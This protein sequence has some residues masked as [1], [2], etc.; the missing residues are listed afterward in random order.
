MTVICLVLT[1]VVLLTIFSGIYVFIV[2]CIRRKEMPWLAAEELQKTSYRKYVDHIQDADRWLAQHNAQDVYITSQDGLKLHALWVPAEN[3][4]GSI[5]FAHGYRSTPLLDFGLV[6]SYYHSKNMNLLLP[7]HRAH[8]KSEGKLITFGVLESNDMQAWIAYHDRF[9]CDCPVI[10]SGLSMGASTV[11]YLANRDL[12]PNVKG[13]I[14]DC[15][16]TSPHEIL[17]CVFRDVTHLW[18]APSLLVAE[19]CARCFGG[20]SFWQCDTRKSLSCSRIP[21][22]IVHGKAD[23]FVPCEMSQEAYDSCTSNKKLLLVEGAG[24]GVSFL[25]EKE[26]YIQLIDAFLAENIFKGD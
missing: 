7:Y 15:G 4:K 21:V 12:S 6:L 8:G 9:L 16:F 14:A 13:I 1:T 5:I 18:A 2:A 22:F 20:F 3:P 19:L 26:K 25:V 23:D 11:L 24:H 17:A 10:L